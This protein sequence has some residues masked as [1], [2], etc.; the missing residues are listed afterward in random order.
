MGRPLQKLYCVA[1]F[2]KELQSEATFFV[3]MDVGPT[4]KSY[5]VMPAFRN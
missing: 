5:S 2:F 1:I 4:F 3:N